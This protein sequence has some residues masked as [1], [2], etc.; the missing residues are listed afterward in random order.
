MA[1]SAQVSGSKAETAN[2]VP[3]QQTLK[4]AE[5]D[6]NSEDPRM[7][8]LVAGDV[9]SIM[10]AERNPAGLWL[11]AFQMATQALSPQPS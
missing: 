10:I 6:F 5:F 3:K 11:N 7:L 2:A 8:C 1:T 4:T 9:L